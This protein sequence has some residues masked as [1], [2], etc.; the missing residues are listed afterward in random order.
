MLI[1]IVITLNETC[2]YSLNEF[3]E[4]YW[5]C[6]LL[7]EVLPRLLFKNIEQYRFIWSLGFLF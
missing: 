2:I 7:L 6:L 1:T 4:K 5:T 3:P